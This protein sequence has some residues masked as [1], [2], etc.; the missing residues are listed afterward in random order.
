MFPLPKWLN[1]DDYVKYHQNSFFGPS[2]KIILLH[3]L[4][5]FSSTGNIRYLETMN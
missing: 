1:A 2:T 4:R 3:Y 5:I